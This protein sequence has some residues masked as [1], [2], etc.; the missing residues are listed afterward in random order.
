MYHLSNTRYPYAKLLTALLDSR[1]RLRNLLIL[2]LFLGILWFFPNSRSPSF[3]PR[4][5]IFVIF[6][7]LVIIISRAYLNAISKGFMV[8]SRKLPEICLENETVEVFIKIR[9]TLPFPFVTASFFDD[10]DAVDIRV[11]P[12]VIL[13]Y[14]DFQQN[15]MACYSYKTNLNR[16]YGNFVVGP[17]TIKIRDPFGFFDRKLSFPIKS[18]IKV[19]LNLPPPEELDLVKENALTP[20]GDSRSTMVGRGMDF[21]GIKEY[22]PGDDIRAMSWLKT[23]QTGKAVIKQFERDTRPDV[24]LAIHTDKSQLR[25]FGFGNTMK[26]IMKIAAAILLESQKKGLPTAFAFCNEGRANYMKI[27]S[28][29]PVYGF[30]TDLMAN[31]K[32]SEDG[33]LHQIVNLTLR[34]AG[35]GSV[36]YLLSH[37]LQLDM[38]LLLSALINMKAMGAKAVVWAIDD[39]TMFKFSKKQENQINWQDFKSMM[40]EMNLDFLLL[41]SKKKPHQAYE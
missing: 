16:G 27:S 22:L 10:F 8:V 13:Q 38:E 11:S 41:P 9:Y 36:I 15:G 4:M 6:P 3:H 1:Y 20:M 29:V 34:K 24:L 19:W 12:E 26:R 33:G 18:N 2:M 28:A 17:S 32:P 39:S 40:E 30:I 35:P 14:K 37:T 21:Y 7:A 23:A 25:G 5:L 31:L